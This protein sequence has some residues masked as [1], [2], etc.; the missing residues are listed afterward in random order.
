MYVKRHF[1]MKIIPNI[2]EMV[3]SIRKEI[4]ETFKKADWMQPNSKI[5]LLE[6][7]KTL[8]Y[9]YI[10]FMKDLLDSKK[11]EKYYKDLI[12]QRDFLTTNLVLKKWKINSNF[13][14][15]AGPYSFEFKKKMPPAIFNAFYNNG[16]ISIKI[17]NFFKN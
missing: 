9:S 6:N 14:V 17:H 15:L 4:Y 11:M 2:I 13:N 8:D 5:K 10:G 7:I 12:I 1:D 3:K 16:T